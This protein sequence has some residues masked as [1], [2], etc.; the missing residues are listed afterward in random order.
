MSRLG[1]YRS[2]RIAGSARTGLVDCFDSELIA[3]ALFEIAD[4]SRR[5]VGQHFFGSF[6]IADRT[7]LLNYI[8]LNRRASVLQRFLHF[9]NLFTL[10][11][12]VH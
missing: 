2:A 1:D 4:C 3:V 7:F 6:P 5:L 8:F 9:Q 12:G 10:V 11:G